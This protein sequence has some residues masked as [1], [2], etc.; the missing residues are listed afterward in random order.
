MSEHSYAEQALRL[1]KEWKGKLEM[2]PRADV[3]TKEELTIAYT[4]DV[5]A[6]WLEI[7]KNV[8]LAYD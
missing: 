3:S 4:P 5:A 6:P 7:E 2:V 1:H 8:D